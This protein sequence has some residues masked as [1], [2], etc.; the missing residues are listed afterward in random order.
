MGLFTWL[1][2]KCTAPAT[3]PP[4]RGEAAGIAA[5]FYLTGHSRPSWPE[6]VPKAAVCPTCLAEVATA[7]TACGQCG[8]GLRCEKPE[9]F[10]TQGVAYRLFMHLR[11]TKEPNVADFLRRTYPHQQGPPWAYA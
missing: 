8:C 6:P 7:A 10:A 11:N 2:G 9:D 4:H 5:G 1:F 3:A